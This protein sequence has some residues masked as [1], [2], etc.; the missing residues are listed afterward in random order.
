MAIAVGMLLPLVGSALLPSDEKP[1]AAVSAQV[2][3]QASPEPAGLQPLAPEA[4]TAQAQARPE[5]L[6]DPPPAPPDSEAPLKSS[7]ARASRKGRVILHVQPPAEIFLGSQRLGA[8]TRQPL[9]LSLPAGQH[10]LT[11]KSAALGVTRQL[12]VKVPA[13]GKVTLQ[14]NL[15]V[16][17]RKRP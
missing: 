9:E 15:G 5:P 11:L 10:T 8:T 6:A 16:S 14:E 3:V 7:K 17:A 12:T 2:P 1:R 13:G 4:L